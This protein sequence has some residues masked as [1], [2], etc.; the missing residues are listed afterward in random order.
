M[1]EYS[2]HLKRLRLEAAEAI[3]KFESIR[4]TV[5]TLVSV[6]VLGAEEAGEVAK[7]LVCPK[8]GGDWREVEHSK[9]TT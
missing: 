6:G 7:P 9:R 2:D 1:S 8:C 4:V 3:Q 5:Q